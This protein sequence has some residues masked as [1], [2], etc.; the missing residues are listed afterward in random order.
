MK[1][2]KYRIKSIGTFVILIL[3]VLGTAGALQ[4]FSLSG[5]E[6][7]TYEDK[8]LFQF[9][10][11]KQALFKRNWPAARRLLEA[12]LKDYPQ[13][14]MRDEGL[15]WLA[16][17]LNKI[18]RE[19]SKQQE[20]ITLKELSLRKLDLLIGTFPKSLWKDDA[21]ELKVEISE[22]LVL[23]GVDRHKATIEKM[24]TSLEKDEVDLKIMALNSLIQLEPETAIPSLKNILF[25]DPDPK[26]R[27]RCVFLLGKQYSQEVLEILEE[28][29]LKEEDVEVKNEAEYWLIQIRTR[30]IPVELNYYAFEAKVVDLSLYKKIP[31]Q[32]LNHFE[33]SHSRPGSSRAK[34][35]IR[36]YFGGGISQFGSQGGGSGIVNQYTRMSQGGVTSQ[37][38]HRLH[39]FQIS[40]LGPSL[41]KGPNEISGRVMF[42]DRESG[43]TYYGDFAVDRKNDNLFVIRRGSDAAVMLLQFEKVKTVEVEPESS[44]PELGKLGRIRDDLLRIFGVD[45]KPVYGTLHANYWGCR[46]HTTGS[47]KLKGVEDFNQAKVEIPVSGGFWTL[48]GHV[49]AVEKD[50]SF[51]GRK[52][53]LIDPSGQLRA[54]A[55]EIIVSSTDPADFKVKGSRMDDREVQDMIKNKQEAEEVYAS[56]FNLKN[57][58]KIY[59]ARK[60]F[61]LEEFEAETIDFERS[62]ALIPS[63]EG[64]WI[65]EG[66][67]VYLRQK[68]MFLASNASLTDPRGPRTIMSKDDILVPLNSPKDYKILD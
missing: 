5:M 11:A 64:T 7:V 8:E 63:P 16:Q 32:K 38:S 10:S 58:V 50:K 53:T 68:N 23:M 47:L 36:S 14:K 54:I 18:S 13:G 48:E 66:D 55:D 33:P 30:L 60:N 25:T 67:I 9:F 4:A 51:Q 3:I 35:H 2:K 21:Q 44:S 31:L 17:S 19:Q 34:S 22:E 12:Y 57:G 56:S 39:D 15:Y 52:A 26:I 37:T 24:T 20:V 40:V 59:Y 6:N 43:D 46:V 41:K 61:D 27:K 28:V 42:K 29:I 1:M 65:L 49:L 62:R 45:K